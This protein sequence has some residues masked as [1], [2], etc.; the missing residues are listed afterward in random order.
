MLSN[1]VDLSKD[2]VRSKWLDMNDFFLDDIARLV[3]GDRRV[4]IFPEGRI[5][6]EA[7]ETRSEEGR[8]LPSYAASPPIMQGSA[9]CETV[10]PFYWGIGK[11]VARTGCVVVP[12]GH[13]GNQRVFPSNTTRHVDF[14]NIKFSGERVHVVVGHPMDFS[15]LLRK[16]LEANPNIS[17][18]IR[19]ES[20]EELELYSHITRCVREA[21][22]ECEAKAKRVVMTERAKKASLDEVD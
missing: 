3:Y 13:Y 9:P 19:G 4:L 21:V 17:F 6:Q 14:R 18:P 2:P 8:W 10:G 11:V 5:W 22:L 7:L 16:F 12:I 1:G 15:K 20:E